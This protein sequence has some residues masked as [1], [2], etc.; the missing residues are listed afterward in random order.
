MVY[1]RGNH[2][3]TLEW[4]GGVMAHREISGFSLQMDSYFSGGLKPV[5]ALH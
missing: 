3:F 4:W 5:L 1:K 2:L